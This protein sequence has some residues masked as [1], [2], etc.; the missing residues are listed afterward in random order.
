MGEVADDPGVGRIDLRR[1]GEVAQAEPGVGGQ[2]QLLEH[3]AR[4]F[5]QDRRAQDLARGG[6]HHLGEALRAAVDQ[7]AIDVGILRL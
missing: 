7:G 4:L 1:S 3:Q 5:A 6:R 2:Y